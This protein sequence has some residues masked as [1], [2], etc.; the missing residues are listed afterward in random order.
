MISPILQLFSISLKKITHNILK[1]FKE[2]SYLQ[3]TSSDSNYD[4]ANNSFSFIEN[5]LYEDL[6]KFKPNYSFILGSGKAINN[7]DDS[8]VIVV[9]SICGFKNFKRGIPHFAVSVSLIRDSKPF[10]SAI[11]LP[12]TDEMF[13]A[14]KD[15]G[16]QLNQKKLHSR[17]T[18][19][20]NKSFLISVD[21]LDS[22]VSSKLKGKNAKATI[23]NCRVIDLC[24]LAA[25]RIDLCC[26]STPASYHEILGGMLIAKEAGIEVNFDQTAPTTINNLTASNLSIKDAL[27]I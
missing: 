13:T 1:D 25:N 15:L 26:F 9:N 27:K 23:S 18:K 20:L 6:S 16:A 11:Y 2:V 14:E 17:D 3:L 21:S 4:Y 24:Y 12:L 10:S 19:T 5:K 7:K 8:N 22:P